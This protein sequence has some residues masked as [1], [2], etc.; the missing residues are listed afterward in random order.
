MFIMHDD[1]PIT[2]GEMHRESDAAVAK[3][4]DFIARVKQDS[5]IYAEFRSVDDLK[6]K[7]VQTLARLRARLDDE[8]PKKPSPPPR[9]FLIAW[10]PRFTIST[11]SR[12]R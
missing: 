6:A 12:K 11:N 10:P 8:N 1:H 3:L 9:K 7:V 4:K 2:R 5:I